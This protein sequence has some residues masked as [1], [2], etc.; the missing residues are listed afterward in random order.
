MNA[1]ANTKHAV[2]FSGASAKQT[3]TLYIDGPHAKVNSELA[4]HFIIILTNTDEIL[5]DIFINN[6]I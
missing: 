6:R 3:I 4:H 2:T 1:R 5:S